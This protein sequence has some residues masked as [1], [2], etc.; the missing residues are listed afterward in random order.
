MQ[1]EIATK[2]WL[3]YCMAA[4]GPV[5]STSCICLTIVA[6]QLI[7]SSVTSCTH[8][9]EAVDAWLINCLVLRFLE[10]ADTL[11]IDVLLGL[12]FCQPLLP[13]SCFPQHILSSY[14]C[15]TAADTTFMRLLSTAGH[16]HR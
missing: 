5:M 16:I 1:H 14:N 9:A 4:V 11:G 7:L 3:R 12:A 10:A 2:V 13:W 8:Y 6:T 15:C